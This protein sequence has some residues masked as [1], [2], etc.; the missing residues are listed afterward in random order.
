MM[1]SAYLYTHAP[2]SVFNNLDSG[3]WPVPS[4][5]LSHLYQ[6]S[7]CLPRD[8]WEITPVQAWFL[9]TERYD[10]RRLLG[11]NGGGTKLNALKEAIGKIVSCRAFGTVMDEREFW[12]VVSRIMGA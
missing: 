11:D 4:L 10:M 2:A 6:M 3:S 1:A 9:L 7:Q 5:E 8:D 12:D